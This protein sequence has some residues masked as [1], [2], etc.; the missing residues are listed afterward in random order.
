MPHKLKTT[1]QNT[2]SSH[3]LRYIWLYVT[4]RP[5]DCIKV[6]V[7]LSSC[8]IRNSTAET[9]KRA[10]AA[11][12]NYIITEFELT[13]MET[14]PFDTSSTLF[15]QSITSN[16]LRNHH[17]NPSWT[18]LLGR[19]GRLPQSHLNGWSQVHFL[20]GSALDG[21]LDL[22]ILWMLYWCAA[23]MSWAD[24]GPITANSFTESTFIR[25]F[26]TFVGSF[27]PV[28]RSKELF[29]CSIKAHAMPRHINFA[30]DFKPHPHCLGWLLP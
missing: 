28:N 3:S 10:S 20:M 19:S 13:W 21:F 1:R 15:Y 6:Q 27:G 23:A 30:N 16:T 17:H 7:S 9:L 8:K 11:H 24:D 22:P 25:D 26:F 5:F 2:W 14:E 29:Y 18:H 12:L 4:F